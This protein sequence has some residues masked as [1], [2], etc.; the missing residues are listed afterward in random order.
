MMLKIDPKQ[1]ATLDDVL[2]DPWVQNSQVCYQLENGEV[3]NAENHTHVLEPAATQPGAQGKD[4]A[5]HH[6]KKP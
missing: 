3:V 6:S 4:T 1:R 5:K 2:A